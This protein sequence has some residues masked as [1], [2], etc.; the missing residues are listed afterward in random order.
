MAVKYT[1][2]EQTDMLLVL[3]FCGGN[4]R[5]SV[6]IYREKFPNRR[7][8]HH[9]TFANVE[10]RLRERGSLLPVTG[11]RGRP[12]IARNP[13][14]EEEILERVGEHP[15][16]SIRSVS[17]QL[18]MSKDV[19][20]K[21]L[22]ENLLYPYHVQVVQELLE[23]CRFIQQKRADDINFH[24]K[25]LFTDEACFTRGGMTNL[26][27]EHVYA[28]ENPHALKQRHYQSEFRINVWAGI[29]GTYLIGPVIL[30]MRLNGRKYLQ[31]LQNVLPEL[32]EEVPLDLRRTMWYLH[33]GAPPHFTINVREHLN[34]Q[35]SNKWIGRGNDAPIRWPPRSPD[36]NICDSFLW[37][38]LKT[39]VY[40]TAINTK[41]ELWNRIQHASHV[42][43]NDH[44]MLQR[45][46]INF[47]RRINCCA[48]E[49]GGHFEHL[50]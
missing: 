44:E 16:I 21:T 7:V 46:Q 20:H 11:D 15:E 30:P 29:I 34:Q 48:Q 36:L 42:I 2:A 47:L 50:L 24:N 26:H 23:F 27:N 45:V 39:E 18:R 10:R 9:R 37:G 3:G 49:G 5:R 4:C 38:A 28:D 13:E 41:N 25:I 6:R 8:P 35:F 40:S 33:D 14:V 19:V 31:M 22:K 32:L 12:R 17:R 43:K 1:F